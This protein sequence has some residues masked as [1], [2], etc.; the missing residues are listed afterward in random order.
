M[1][2]SCKLLCK[3]GIY[4]KEDIIRYSIIFLFLLMSFNVSAQNIPFISTWKTTVADET[5]K[6]AP[7]ETSKFDYSVDW[8]DGVEEQYKDNSVISHTYKNPDEYTVTITGVFTSMKLAGADLTPEKITGIKQWGNVGWES[9][10]Y[11]LAECINLQ[12]VTGDSRGLEGVTDMSG[13][14]SEATSF[15]G[16]ELYYWNVENVTKM[17]NMF[18][19]S[20]S[21][22]G[23]LSKWK[24]DNVTSTIEM[25]RG[26]T[27][28]NRDLS[29][30]NVAKV[31]K[32]TNM[33]LEAELEIQNYEALLHSW[34]STASTQSDV[35]FH[36]GTSKYSAC[37][38][39]DI[40]TL[41]SKWGNS[42]FEGG[43][44]WNTP[45]ASK[46]KNIVECQKYPVQLLDAN[47][48]LESSGGAVWYTSETGGEK[49]EMP[50]LSKVG[51]VEYYADYEI[52]TCVST[53]R[54][55]VI[56][57]ITPSNNKPY[58][59]VEGD[60]IC[61]GGDTEGKS[62]VL[63]VI[64]S[65]Y[66]SYQ[67]K[68]QW[69]KDGEEIDGATQKT[70]EIKSLTDEAIGD[71]SVDIANIESKDVYTS[72]YY[73]HLNSSIEQ[74]WDDIVYIPNKD[75]MYESYQ[76]Y[77]N[78]EMIKG[79]TRQFYQEKSDD[80]S[81]MYSVEVVLR[82]G[83]ARIMSCERG[84]KKV[85]KPSEKVSV[86]LYPNP[87]MKSDNLHI[88]LETNNKLSLKKAEL[89]IYSLS[90]ILMDKKEIIGQEVNY[91][92]SSLE[93]GTYIVLIKI[94]EEEKLVKKIIVR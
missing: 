61:G 38:T 5:I 86:I 30:W 91:D 69:S 56:L 87:L 60:S 20:T 14:F 11:A 74:K 13:L 8:G 33:F 35:G 31:T 19:K 34:A 50:T 16:N 32:A 80:R 66:N 82:D 1:I 76:W 28:F 23:D 75:D 67:L 63:S 21:F 2:N 18:Y 45:D 39:D 78:G 85:E 43:D 42:I 89:H 29:G 6:I 53:T 81:G 70:Y 83:G 55:K 7:S 4:I 65:C 22:N 62:I 51:K 90:G 49:V 58:I 44:A 15:E 40:A 92:S 47:N 24:V 27:S 26:A 72:S 77:K 25:F 68:Y 84:L 17:D 10:D 59:E 71:Y 94:G 3:K 36:G 79:A 73:L 52:G 48:A 12:E 57:E 54:T 93:I 41:K 9:L 37:V 64:T 88:K 46:G